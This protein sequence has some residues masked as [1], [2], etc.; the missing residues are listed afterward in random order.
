MTTA[1]AL[2]LALRRKPSPVTVGLRGP[3]GASV[4][5]L[6]DVAPT[7]VVAV[8]GPPGPAGSAVRFDVTSASASWVIAHAF[9]R[10]PI[11]SVYLA[12]GELV[13][14]DV[15]ATASTIN[16]VFPT[17]KTGFVIAA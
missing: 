13:L 11:V 5:P 3:E 2:R 9:G 16:V 1:A 7:R 14:T 15:F 10:V 4:Q 8:M 6:A 12:S 17:P